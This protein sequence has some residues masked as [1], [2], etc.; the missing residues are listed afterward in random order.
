VYGAVSSWNRGGTSDALPFR[1]YSKARIGS[2]PIHPMLVA[3]PIGLF[4]ATAAALL[5]YMGTSD[6]FYYRAAMVA[7]VAG[8]VA[9]LAAAVPGAIDL[10]S[11]PK[12]SQARSTGF[13]HAGFALGAVGLFAV[14]ALVLWRG[15][16]DRTMV[17]G[18]YELDATIP[19]AICIAG[20]LTLTVVGTL[21]WTL[22]QTHH[23]GVKP[24][25]IRPSE[26]A[27]ARTSDPSGEFDD[28][29]TPVYGAGL[30]PPSHGQ[31]QSFRH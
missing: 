29:A 21:G 12:S 6:L 15:W 5:A 23:V 3:L 7:N 19:L 30:A 25:F 31:L 8:V 22:V 20:M 27:A 11:L 18:A 17:Y 2:H 1:M 28:L 4:T 16:H 13:K 10:L 9:A 26:R 24:T 14:S